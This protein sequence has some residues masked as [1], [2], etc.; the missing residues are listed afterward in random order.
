MEIFARGTLRF[1]ISTRLIY[2]HQITANEL[3][4]ERE[5]RVKDKK[6]VQY[7]AWKTE[8]KETIGNA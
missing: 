1:V 7:F 6:C 5:K 4:K 3:G 8:K 2:V